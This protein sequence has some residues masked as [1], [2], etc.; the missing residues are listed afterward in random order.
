MI[1]S[2]L[3]IIAVAAVVAAPAQAA[4]FKQA[5]R[6]R[7]EKL[8]RSLGSRTSLLV[9]DT[10]GRTLASVRPSTRRP[11][12][13]VTKL[14]TS[15]AVLLGLT[16]P[17]R[18]TVELTGPLG[19]DGTLTGHII[20]HGGGDA[21]LDDRGLT[22][23]RDAVLNAGVK[24]ITGRVIGDGSLFDTAAGGPATQLA[25]DPEFDGAVGA[26]TFEH[27]R[28]APGGPFQVDPAAA[29]AARFDDLLEAAG[30]TLPLGA[31]SG[32]VPAGPPLAFTDG[33]LPALLRAMNTDSSA[34][35]AEDLGK[36]LAAQRTGQPGTTA[37]AAKAIGDVVRAR[38][39]VRPVL[40]DSA[41]FAAGSKA[42]ARDVTKLLRQM[43][44]RPSFRAS[45][46]RAGE[47]TLRDRAVPTGCRVKTGT[48]RTAK[49]T[50]LAGICRGRVFA[51]LA[52]GP[53]AERARAVQ[54]QI[55]QVLAS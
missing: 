33:D 18:T 2:A 43:D 16:T 42:S 34:V 12:G 50:A 48:L 45:L 40:A 47:G 11:L 41:G 17:P 3:S 5:D 46:A 19:P 31:G 7:V 8:A 14:F 10:R 24:R 37:A 15:S 25:F 6:T 21:G 54:D 52:V 39:G 9:T 32:T 53:S 26:L 49:A 1:R 23:L 44:K 51:I 36:L 35:T 38:L 28:S 13:S 4:T 55:T 30:V 27:G 22:Y 20:L 29:T